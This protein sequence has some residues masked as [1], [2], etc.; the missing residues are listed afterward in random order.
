VLNYIADRGVKKERLSISLDSIL[1]EVVIED[2]IK[3]HHTP[4][5][6]RR[7]EVVILE[8]SVFN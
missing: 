3:G 1:S 4:E 2:Y 6:S 8:R 7:L 5:E